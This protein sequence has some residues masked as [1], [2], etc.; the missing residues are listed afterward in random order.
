MKIVVIN[1]LLLAMTIPLQAQIVINEV[2]FDPATVGN[3][4]GAEYVELCNSDSV[5][6]DPS[7]WQIVDGTGNPQATLPAALPLIQPQGFLLVASDTS[8][9]DRFP[10]LRDSANVVVIGK[11]SFSLNNDEDDVI[12]LD[13][14]GTPLDRLHYSDSWHRRDLGSTRG[15]SLE[16]ISLSGPTRDERNWSSSPAREGGTPAALNAITIPVVVPEALLLIDPLVVSPDGDGFQDFTRISFKLPSA[17]ARVAITIYDRQGRAVR[18]LVGNELAPAQG[19]FIWDGGDDSGRRL[20]IGVYIVRI[21]VWDD[22]ATQTAGTQTY[23]VV[24]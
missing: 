7:R 6:I 22:H 23:V 12:L 1:L 20:Q 16:R 18:H 8:I 11:A 17:F 3:R 5:A 4:T 19:E 13:A 2:M 14:Q 9:Y 15:I 21:E 24:R 10:W